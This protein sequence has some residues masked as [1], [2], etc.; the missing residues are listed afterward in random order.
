[1]YIDNKEYYTF[2]DVLLSPQYSEIASRTE[3]D[4]STT[5]AGVKLDIPI[6]SSNM[7]TVTGLEMA[8]AMGRA[9]G[10]GI[11][12]R[13]AELD[14]IAGWIRFLNDSG[15]PAVPSI[16]VKPSDLEAAKLYS[17]YDVSAICVDVAHGHH[18]EVEKTIAQLKKLNFK[19]IAGN[20]ATGGGAVFLANAGADAIKV[21]IGPSGVCSTRGVTGHGVPQLSAILDCAEALKYWWP[22]ISLIADGGMRSSADVIKALGAGANAVMLGGILA[23][24]D[25]CPVVLD[26]DGNRVYRGMASSEAQLSFRGKVNNGCAEG[27][28]ATV[29]NRGPVAKT[30]EAL[31]GGIRSGLSYS[32]CRNLQEFRENAIFIRVSGNTALENSTH[33]L[34]K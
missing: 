6:I 14:K 21:G 13:Y 26:K 18:K 33:T 27:V 1:M 2:D 32:G 12:H 10:L 3:V 7:D 31:V 17:Y 9:G 11:L 16:G 29:P 23:G 4:V 25:E 20:V 24:H 15:Q 30:L 5:V 28:A 8:W 34:I 22:N 19:V